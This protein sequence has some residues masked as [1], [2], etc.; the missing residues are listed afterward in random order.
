MDWLCFGVLAGTTNGLSGLADI[1]SALLLVVPG[2]LAVVLWSPFL[3]S[4]RL[5]S[6]FRHLPPAN[7]L[8]SSYLVVGVA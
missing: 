3:L 2:F 6:L 1:R 4:G 5:R 7:S 8:L